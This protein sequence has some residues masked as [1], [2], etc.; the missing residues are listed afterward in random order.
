ML[1]NVLQA[2]AQVK[3]ACLLAQAFA[4]MIRSQDAAGLESWL[5]QAENQGIPEFRR[6]AAGIKRDRA[7]VFAALTSEWS[8][9]QVEGAGS[10]PEAH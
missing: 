6:F 3:A 7:A 2:H 5:E 4:Q 10:S 9:G 1:V 8:Q